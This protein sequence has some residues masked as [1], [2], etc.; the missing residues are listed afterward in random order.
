MWRRA[1]KCC[2]LY[3]LQPMQCQHQLQ[4]Q[5]PAVALQEIVSI[6]S[7]GGSD[8]VLIFAEL[9]A[10]EGLWRKINVYM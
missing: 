4:R 3:K 9:W 8:K 2:L 7:Q 6:K 1:V 10:S 5:L